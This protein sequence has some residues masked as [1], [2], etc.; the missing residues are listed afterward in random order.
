MSSMT[1]AWYERLADN[2]VGMF[3]PKG[4]ALRKHFRKMEKD[5]DYRAA[6]DIY[7]RLRGYNAAGHSKTH[8]QWPGSSGR[9]ADAEINNDLWTMRNRSRAANRD[10]ALSSG[11]TQTLIRGVVGTGLRPQARTGDEAKD[12]A[13]EAVWAIRAPQLDRG[14]GNLIHGSH[15]RMAYAKRV[16]DGDVFLRPAVDGPGEPIW[17]E[18]IEADRVRTPADA[19]PED[20]KGRIISGVEKDGFGR[21]VAYW[22][23]QRHP[24]DW[25][26]WDT[27][28]G[29]EAIP[30]PSAYS[31]K[32]FD[33]VDA[34]SVCH[35]RSRVLRPG[36]TRGV[37][38]CHAVMQDLRDLDLLM[39]A[40]L[41]RT[42][43]AACLAAFI[44]SPLSTDNLLQVTAEDYGYILDDAIQ[45]G[46]IF[47]LFPGEKVDFINP[48]AGVPDLQQFVFLLASRIGSAIGLSPQAILRQ[49]QGVNY[50]GART[51]KI[52]DRQ[53]YRGERADFGGH[54]LSWEWR[55]V[56]E[57]ELLRGNELLRDA[58]VEPKDLKRV[59]WIG[60]EE[61]WVD[62]QAEATATEIKL[63]IGLT[64]KQI[65]A[66]R[67]GR[68]WKQIL[69]DQLI[70]EQEEMLLRQQ[71]GLP[72]KLEKEQGAQGNSPS[73]AA[74]PPLKLIPPEESETAPVDEYDDG[75]ESQPLDPATYGQPGKGAVA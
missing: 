16:E 61:E 3:S 8:T 48:T 46:S 53:T 19:M 60:D 41:K 29:P 62:P 22:I 18:V 6:F 11:I 20:P 21:V 69:K 33:R 74:K 36:Q 49:W 57:D 66:Q 50:S 7:A 34:G 63:R 72:S 31:K 70:E 42:Q 75:A 30:F 4:K 67:L 12:A 44:E 26:L 40:A 17:I 37:P 35:D 28:L 14:N 56:M 32:Y 25:V 10:D 65:E 39:L 64:S 47:R 73:S 38:I 51:I 55:V 5:G 27:K 54:V 23:L 24:G 43:V 9:S 13:L 2:V 71:M 52:D 45:P 59:E 58:G 15:Q 1:D 68:N